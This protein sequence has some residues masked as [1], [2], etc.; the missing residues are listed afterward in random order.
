MNTVYEFSRE[1]GMWELFAGAERWPDKKPPVYVE[2]GK[3]LLVADCNGVECSH[4]NYPDS[5]WVLRA[6]LATQAVAIAL[7]AGLP[8]DFVPKHYGF[9]K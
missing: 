4:E 8:A 9:T 2:I 3:W 7:L 6:P 1:N 5:V